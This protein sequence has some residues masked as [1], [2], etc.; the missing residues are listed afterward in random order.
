MEITKENI[1]RLLKEGHDEA[2]YFV[3]KN[4]FHALCFTA[5]KIIRDNDVAE[6]MV[7]K[8]IL[9]IW[10]N[11]DKLDEN[12]NIYYYLNK[13]V[14]NNCLMH[15]RS[16]GRLKQREDR[17][18]MSQD[19]FVSPDGLASTELLEM[20]NKA[21]SELSKQQQDIFRM[22]RFDG[23]TYREIAEKLEINQKT[24]EYH[25]SIALKKVYSSLKGYVNVFILVFLEILFKIL[26]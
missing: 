5:Q 8:T 26:G 22:N 23:F 24:V 20:L 1:T 12:E 6:D 14:Y 2:Y 3:Y 15:I 13:T 11:R 9:K 4:Y 25:M 7:Q 18:M 10:E 19:S 21:L 17:Y 16:E